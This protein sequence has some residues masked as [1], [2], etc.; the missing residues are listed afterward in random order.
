MRKRSEAMG[1]KQNPKICGESL[2]HDADN[3]NL[4]YDYGEYK[5]E[6]LM[7][8]MDSHMYIYNYIYMQF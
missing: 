8:F 1:E 6:W 3:T 7:V 2:R 4:G 5:G